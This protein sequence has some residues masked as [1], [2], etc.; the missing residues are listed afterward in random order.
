MNNNDNER[1]FNT[2]LWFLIGIIIVQI[3]ILAG[4]VLAILIQ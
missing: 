3:T 2:F 1:D 4:F